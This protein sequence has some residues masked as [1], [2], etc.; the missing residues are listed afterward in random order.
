V[1]GSSENGPVFGFSVAILPSFLQVARHH[2]RIMDNLY[3]GA[4][5]PVASR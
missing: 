2:G 1:N 3:E 4:I 5:E